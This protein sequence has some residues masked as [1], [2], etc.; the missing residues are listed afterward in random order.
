[1]NFE[2]CPSAG[3]GS[4]LWRDSVV[5]AVSHTER[6]GREHGKKA[7]QRGRKRMREED[8]RERD[9]EREE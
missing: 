1:M 4:A 9:D 2:T 5:H 7:E 3:T 6:R 8:M